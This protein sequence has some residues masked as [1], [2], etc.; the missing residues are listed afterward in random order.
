M[1]DLPSLPDGFPL[2]AS[3]LNAISVALF[4]GCTTGD[5]DLYIDPAGS[6]VTGTGLIGA[7]YATPARAKLD[8][9]RRVEHT[10]H[11]H[12]PAGA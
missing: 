11:L 2:E 9:P 7:P 5:F 1:R 3:K 8:I 6:D 12:V 10:V 4:N